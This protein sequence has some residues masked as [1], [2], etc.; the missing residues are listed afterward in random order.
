MYGTVNECILCRVLLPLH[1]AL[2]ELW[3]VACRGIR[4]SDFM[5]SHPV[6]RDMTMDDTFV[7]KYGAKAEVSH[8]SRL[9]AEITRA[10]E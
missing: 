3:D 6:K 10:E 2:C 9:D 8:P 1:W 7:G 5:V 4:R